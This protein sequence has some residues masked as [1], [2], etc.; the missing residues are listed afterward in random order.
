MLGEIVYV[1]VGIASIVIMWRIGIIYRLLPKSL[2]P[3]ILAELDSLKVSAPNLKST[4]D[5][6]HSISK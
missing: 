6:S 1:L 2:A 5:T 4:S 3:K